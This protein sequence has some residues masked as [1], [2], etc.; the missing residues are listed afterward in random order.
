[1]KTALGLAAAAAGG[2]TF[3]RIIRDTA[4]F[5]DTMLG[6]KAVFGATEAQMMAL[7]KQEASLAILIRLSS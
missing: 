5:E 7:Q 2:L 6:L 3:S 1:M 4:Q